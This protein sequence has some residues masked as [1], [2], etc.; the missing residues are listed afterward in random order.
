LLL[1]QPDQGSAQAIGRAFGKPKAAGECVGELGPRQLHEAQEPFLR[2]P[3]SLLLRPNESGERL[4]HDATG[5]LCQQLMRVGRIVGGRA[6]SSSGNLLR[7]LS[8]C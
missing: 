4:A 8:A 2:D 6:C 3:P 5:V 7:R 1:R